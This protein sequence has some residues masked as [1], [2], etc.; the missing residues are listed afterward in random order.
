MG[1]CIFIDSSITTSWST[2]I[3]SPALTRNSSTTPAMLDTMRFIGT[4]PRIIHQRLHRVNRVAA[5]GETCLLSLVN[6]V[7]CDQLIAQRLKRRNRIHNQ[8]RGQAK[9]IDILGVFSLHHLAERLAFFLGHRGNLVCKDG[10]YCSFGAHHGDLR[11]GQRNYSVGAKGRSRHRVEAR[12]V[13]LAYDNAYFRH[14]SLR[15]RSNKLCSMTDNACSLYRRADHEPRDVRQEQQ[16]DVEGIAGI[17]EARS[18][19]RCICED[20]TS[21][22]ARLIGDDAD[23]VPVQARITGNEFGREEFLDLK[24]AAAIYQ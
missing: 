9:N 1:I 14:Y 23:R 8:F 13:A 17:D 20:H 5:L 3:F 24:E 10:I 4:A 15:N 12:A 19:I 11:R 7:A 2:A 22:D 6:A 16:R 18:L 21:F